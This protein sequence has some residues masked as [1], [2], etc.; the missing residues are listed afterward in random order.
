[1]HRGRYAF[2][3]GKNVYDITSEL[4]GFQKKQIKSLDLKD[5]F[6]GLDIGMTKGR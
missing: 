1:D 3:V 4:K 5:K 2:L 6:V